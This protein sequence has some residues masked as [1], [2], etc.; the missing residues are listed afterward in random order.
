MKKL[1]N[2]NDTVL[3]VAF[4][5]QAP[6]IAADLDGHA[7]VHQQ[8]GMQAEE[9]WGGY[10]FWQAWLFFCSFFSMIP[11]VLSQSS[12]LYLDAGFRRP[13]TKSVGTDLKIER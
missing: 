8:P 1:C 10:F 6:M 7:C 4:A 5:K 3:T 12:A 9:A 13:Q 2:E 11:V